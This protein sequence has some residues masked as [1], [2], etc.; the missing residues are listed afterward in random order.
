M[1]S[2]LHNAI[3]GFMAAAIIPSTAQAVHS[4]T[5][6][7]SPVRF[8]ARRQFL[9]LA[10]SAAALPGAPHIALAQPY[11]TRPVRVI[12]P[13]AA[14]GAVDVCARLMGQWLSERLGQPFLIEN[15][16]G[17]GGNIG[18]E[19]VVR[20]P[21]DGYTLLLVS[22]L[23]AIGA[24]LYQRLSFDF[25]R[26][27]VPVASIE[28]LPLIVIVNPAVPAKTVPELIA[29]AKGNPGKISVGSG[30]PTNQVCSELF[31]M[32]AGINMLHVPYR[33]EAPALADLIGGQVEVM[34]ATTGSA[35]QY[36]HSGA[37]RI[38]AV[39][40][41]TRLATLPDIP[42]VGEFLPGYEATSWLG[43]GAPKNT[44]NEIID[45]LN[46]ELNE[47]LADPVMQSRIAQL[48]ATVFRGSPGDFEK[49]IAQEIEKWKKVIQLAN[50]KAD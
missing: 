2:I 40:T 25:R 3:T 14:G 21:A 20:A 46:K 38:L 50:I 49:H 31:K 34:I 15:R 22:A 47:G 26:D 13:V 32:M 27:I 1:W 24:T 8:L 12:V 5:A 28:R 30:G 17:G 11:P 18:I 6:I 45:K 48:G 43:V 19:A 9:K 23:A 37:L 33:G 41:E 16:P 35:M 39:T 7:R 42:T 29:Y 36:V 4:K 44:P 10:A